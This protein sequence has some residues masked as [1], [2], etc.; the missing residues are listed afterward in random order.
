MARTE[1]IQIYSTL[2]YFHDG[3]VP[4][5]AVKVQQTGFCN[6]ISSVFYEVRLDFKYYLYV[7]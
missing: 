6:G 3:N 1:E 7:F 4:R 5:V 2:K